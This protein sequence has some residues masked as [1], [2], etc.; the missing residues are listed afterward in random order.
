M[1]LSIT[2]LLLFVV[3]LG[4]TSPTSAQ[5]KPDTAQLQSARFVDHG[6]GTISD[7]QTGLMW[8]KASTPTIPS[9]APCSTNKEVRNTVAFV[10]CLN[11]NKLAGHSDWRLPS[12]L[13]L[14]SLCNKTGDVSR[15]KQAVS[16][17]NCNDG[18]VDMKSWLTQQGFTTFPVSGATSGADSFLSSSKSDGLS[19][20]VG[21]R[22]YG[23]LIWLK[24]A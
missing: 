6:D 13:E 8:T 3:S 5:N 9:A 11:Q 12:I 23:A 16:M 19:F 4:F 24:A 14:A 2:L 15:L 10:N 21:L 18:P 22:S 1:K 20:P 7:K 17:G